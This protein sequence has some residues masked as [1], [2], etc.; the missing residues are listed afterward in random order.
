MQSSLSSCLLSKMHV[1]LLAFD[2]QTLVQ[3]AASLP[4]FADDGVD[5]SRG[6]V[7]GTVTFYESKPDRFL[8]FAVD[9]GTSRV[10]CIL[11]FNHISSPVL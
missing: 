1:K 5:L 9:D 2:L 7:P 10:P 11:W 6:E 3:T 8:K 4:M